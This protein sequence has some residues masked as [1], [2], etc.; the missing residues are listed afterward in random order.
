MRGNPEDE[1]LTSGQLHNKYQIEAIN[2]RLYRLAEK[3]WNKL[4]VTDEDLIRQSEEENDDPLAR[5]HF[6]WR[7][8]TPYIGNNEP[9]PIYSTA[10]NH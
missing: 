5:D 3:I 2:V 4:S 10:D 9:Q 8:I 6:W 7:R 1:I